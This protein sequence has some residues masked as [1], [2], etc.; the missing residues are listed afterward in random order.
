[1]FSTKVGSR[2]LPRAHN[3]TLVVF[4][5]LCTETYD[6]PFDNDYLGHAYIQEPVFPEL[7]VCRSPTTSTASMKTAARDLYCSLLFLRH[8][9]TH[10]NRV[11]LPVQ[12]HRVPTA[13]TAASISALNPGREQAWSLDRQHIPPFILLVSGLPKGT[14][15]TLKLLLGSTYFSWDFSVVPTTHISIFTRVLCS[16]GILSTVEHD[17]EVESISYK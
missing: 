9:P 6:T 15:G 17:E 1:M 3:G 13:R 4:C 14:I 8:L 12:D 7:R 11:N 5:L 2:S 16:R 10:N